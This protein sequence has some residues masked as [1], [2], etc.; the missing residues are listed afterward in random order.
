MTSLQLTIVN[1]SWSASLPC[2]VIEVG[3]QNQKQR[4]PHDHE[5]MWLWFGY[6]F[7][8]SMVYSAYGAFSRWIRHWNIMINFKHLVA[9]LNHIQV[10]Q[11]LAKVLAF[12]IEHF[13]APSNVEPRILVFTIIP[14]CTLMCMLHKNDNYR[15][16]QIFPDMGRQI[17]NPQL[18]SIQMGYGMSFGHSNPFQR[19]VK[20]RDRS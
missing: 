13:G 5:K 2:N 20:K 18:L 19:P 7:D 3:L 11:K 8:G 16:R 12:I 14:W 6:A 4:A 15:K 17:R 9:H 10:Q 1:W